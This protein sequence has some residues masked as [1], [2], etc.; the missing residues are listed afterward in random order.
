[1]CTRGEFYRMAQLNGFGGEYV[2]ECPQACVET[3]AACVGYSLIPGGRTHTPGGAVMKKKKLGVSD[4]PYD[5]GRW[6][7]DGG[8]WVTDGGW[9]VTDGG[10]C[11]T[12]GGW[13]V[14][15]GGWCVPDGCWWVTDG[16]WWVA[17][18]HQRVDAI[19]KK[20]GVSPL[21]APP[22]TPSALSFWTPPS[23]APTHRPGPRRSATGPA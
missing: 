12:D 22:A 1:M 10:W 7:I 21:M 6:V 3:G 14:T 18:K 5:G 11:V 4:T 15:D 20:K 8:W 16:G 13:W 19:V 2:T 9:W 23:N 17:T